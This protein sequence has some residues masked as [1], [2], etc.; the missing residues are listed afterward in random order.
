MAEYYTLESVRNQII[1]NGWTVNAVYCLGD[2][3]V[4]DIAEDFPLDWE[5]CPCKMETLCTSRNIKACF[6]RIGIFKNDMD[7][8]TSFFIE[9]IY[10]REAKKG[11]IRPNQMSLRSYIDSGRIDKRALKT[12]VA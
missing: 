3:R 2:Q 10:L 12:I 4:V 8:N 7:I 1:Q 5:Y 11:I 9:I 6:V